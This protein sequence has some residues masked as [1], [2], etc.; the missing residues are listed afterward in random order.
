ML[1]KLVN[2]EPAS[3]GITGSNYISSAGYFEGR[4]YLNNQDT[5]EE[6]NLFVCTKDW[7]WVKE[8][9]CYNLNL[10]DINTNIESHK[11]S[12]EL[13]GCYVGILDSSSC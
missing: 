8:G 12:S 9:M 1:A 10:D 5:G 4:L 6:Y 7:S 3:D 2:I 11:F 13:S